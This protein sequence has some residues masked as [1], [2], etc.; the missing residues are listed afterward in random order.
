MIIPFGEWMPDLPDFT[1][2]GATV[3]KNVIPVAKGYQ[4][5]RALT[6]TTDAMDAYA[7]GGMTARDKDGNVYV[8]IGNETKLYK[9]SSST[10]S[11]SSKVGGYAT[12]AEERWEFAKWGETVIATNFSDAV[13]S[14]TI[15]AAAFADLA[16]SPPKARHI[17]VVRDFVVLGNIFDSGDGN[18]P[19]RVRWSAI[20][21]PESWT[22][23]AATQSDEQDLPEGGWVRGIVG[24]EYGVVFM[25][26]QIVRMTYVGS[27]VIFQ[28]DVVESSRGTLIPGSIAKLGATIFY[29]A[30]D[31][32]YAL[33]NGAT[34]QPIGIEK[35]DRTLGADLDLDNLHRVSS[36]VDPVNKVVVWAYPSVSSDGTPDKL[37]IYNW[38]TNRW[39]QAEVESELVMNGQA[40]GISMDDLDALTTNLDTFTTSLD[41]QTLAG[42]SL[43]L[44]GVDTAHKQGGFD[45]TP[46][47]ATL[48]TGEFQPV[49]GRRSY[50]RAVR[51]LTDG[52]T[53]SVVIRS[54][55]RQADSLTD[56]A[57]S[58]VNA[59]GICPVRVSS[60]YFRVQETISGGFTDAQGV[61]VDAVQD[62]MR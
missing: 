1:N 16:G 41:S 33:T 18:V 12:A 49:R 6:A 25:E 8:Y 61:E 27:P 44:A 22:I 57:S 48:E 38:S 59:D 53:S 26:R 36:A 62:G 11:N 40:F 24:G 2:P 20:N 3:A 46:L 37:A 4:Q 23:D 28:F 29:W 15:G 45:G 9:A 13:Q 42:G 52:A 5:L 55:T 31:G 19:H 50:L 54:R 51:P 35:V 14:S 10:L 30:P 43:L 58:A 21:N 17:G 56:S 32:F 60:R 7:R 39:S 47:T 34:S